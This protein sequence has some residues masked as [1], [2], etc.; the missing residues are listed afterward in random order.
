MESAIWFCYLHIIHEFKRN[1][2]FQYKR[3]PPSR[4]PRSHAPGR[5]SW[6]VFVKRMTRLN[7]NCIWVSAIKV[8]S[9]S[10]LAITSTSTTSNNCLTTMQTGAMQAWKLLF[11]VSFSSMVFLVCF[12]YP[13]LS[14]N[15]NILVTRLTRPR[16]R[17]KYLKNSSRFFHRCFYYCSFIF[18]LTSA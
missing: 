15:D 6:S 2:W 3:T 13:N 10:I 17:S 7:L 5:G 11:V 14:G 8:W 16:D 1:G 12:W 4:T 9:E 18:G